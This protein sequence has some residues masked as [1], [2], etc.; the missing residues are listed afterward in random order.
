MAGCPKPAILSCCMETQDAAELGEHTPCQACCL[1]DL[2]LL[3][4]PAARDTCTYNCCCPAGTSQRP[5]AFSAAVVQHICSTLEAVHNGSILLSC[6]HVADLASRRGMQ[7]RTSGPAAQLTF[8]I[9]FSQWLPHTGHGA[10]LA[11]RRRMLRM[12]QRTPKTTCPASPR[13]L[14]RRPTTRPAG[15]STNCQGLK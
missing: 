11:R 15:E 12:L 8:E 10:G 1:R 3:V 13:A 2:Q 6:R 5:A 7:P 14:V 9:T 4:L